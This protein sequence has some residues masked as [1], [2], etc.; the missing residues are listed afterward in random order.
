M[1]AA[2]IGSLQTELDEF[3]GEFADCFG[4]PEPREHLRTYIKG[5]LSD[6]PRKSIEPI[7]LEAGIAPRTLQE[8]LSTARWDQDLMR[9][10]L[11]QQ[12]TRHYSHLQAIAAIDETSC[13]KK[14]DMTP[15][16]KAQWCGSRGKKD[17]CVVTV[18]LSYATPEGFRAL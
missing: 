10:R 11:Q 4:R 7:A 1:D 18:H 9:Q 5:Q 8:F 17:N 3:L 12:V 15:G 13:A 2:Q 16:V 6:L 14:G